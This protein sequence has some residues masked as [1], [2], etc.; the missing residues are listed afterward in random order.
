MFLTEMVVHC[1]R[2]EK[3][4]LANRDTTGAYAEYVAVSTH[5]LIHKPAHL[6]WEESA[7]IPETWITATQA[8]Y[9]VGCFSEGKTVLWHAGASSVSIAGHQL[10]RAGGASA[11]YSTTRSD[12]KC[13]FC[14]RELGATASFNQT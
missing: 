12:E 10:S 11:L 14:V 5:M 4:G 13:E 7:G 1:S 6:S 3:K 2:R 8:L 9:L